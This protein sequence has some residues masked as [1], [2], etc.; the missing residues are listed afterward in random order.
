MV[1]ISAGSA[2]GPQGNALGVCGSGGLGRGIAQGG[3][4]NAQGSCLQEFA[5]AGIS[6]S[7][8]FGG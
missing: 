2:Q 8:R 6:A 1:T 4:R 7:L 5:A 3:C